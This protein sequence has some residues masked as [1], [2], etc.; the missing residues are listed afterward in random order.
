MRKGKK[1]K[2]P[3]RY[4]CEFSSQAKH[5]P[6]GNDIGICKDCGWRKTVTVQRHRNDTGLDTKTA[7]LSPLQ[8]KCPVCR[9]EMS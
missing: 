7:H 1:A 9:K 2:Q 5:R 8:I 4:G 3:I 6:S